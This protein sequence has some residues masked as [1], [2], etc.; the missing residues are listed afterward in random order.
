MKI[1]TAESMEESTAVI[2]D[3]LDTPSIEI[4]SECGQKC[5]I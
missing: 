4:G 5:N 1:R 3:I 2:S